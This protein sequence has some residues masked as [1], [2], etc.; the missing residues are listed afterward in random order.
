MLGLGKYKIGTAEKGNIN[1]PGR[2][3]VQWHSAST[4]ELYPLRSSAKVQKKNPNQ[5]CVKL[6]TPSPGATVSC[7]NNRDKSSGQRPVC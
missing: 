1:F 4:Q 5:N 6:F 7:S 2:S 3:T